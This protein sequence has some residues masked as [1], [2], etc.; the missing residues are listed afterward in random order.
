MP[1]VQISQIKHRRG[2]QENLPQLGSAELG[3]SIDKQRLYIGSG[4]REEGAPT[5]DNIEIITETSPQ[6][7]EL[8]SQTE[9]AYYTQDLDAG[10]ST[11]LSRAIA[12]LDAVVDENIQNG[13]TLYTP[14]I[15]ITYQITRD[16][17]SRSGIFKASRNTST[18][19]VIY[20]DDYTESDDMGINL[21][22]EYDSGGGPNTANMDIYAQ[23]TSGSVAI[24]SYKV[25]VYLKNLNL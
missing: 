3:W 13:Y 15:I 4:T 14:D 7:V 1:I 17:S 23:L 8:Q 25:E 22:A 6:W 24:I 10:T 19:V 2:L 20:D 5:E 21:I 9:S 12:L 16:N 18:N 11:S